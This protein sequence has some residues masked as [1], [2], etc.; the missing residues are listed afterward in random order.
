MLVRS[1][2]F[3]EAKYDRKVLFCVALLNG[4][5]A[6]GWS[7]RLHRIALCA[8]PSGSTGPY[9]AA[10]IAVGLAFAWISTIVACCAAARASHHGKKGRKPSPLPIY[11]SRPVI[12]SPVIIHAGNFSENEREDNGMLTSFADVPL[13]DLGSMRG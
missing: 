5:A 11:V 10:P 13:E 8:N 1:C 7:I 6:V 12:S 4:C 9:C 2:V 3:S